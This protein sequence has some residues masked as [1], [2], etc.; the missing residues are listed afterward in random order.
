MR[1]LAISIQL[2]FLPHQ[3]VHLVIFWAVSMYMAEVFLP[4]LPPTKTGW[5]QV[6]QKQKLFAITLRFYGTA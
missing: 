5:C 6:M 3:N 2:T 4:P 1:F